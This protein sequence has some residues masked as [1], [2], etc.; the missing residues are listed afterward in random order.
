MSLPFVKIVSQRHKA[1]CGI[2]ALAMLLGT[3]YED[4]F[5][6]FSHTRRSATDPRVYGMHTK[7]I[8]ATARRLKVELTM[9]R[10][11][12]LESSIGL[13]TVEKLDPKPD[14]FVQHLVLL[15]FGLIFD[16]DGIVWEP[17]D[18]FEQFGFKPVSILTEE[19]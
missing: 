6:A 19:P 14:E 12:D 8:V 13:L 17:S 10:A 4:V 5:A 9:H 7:Q 15:K 1:D 2:A 16:T 11:F 18:Y 3:N